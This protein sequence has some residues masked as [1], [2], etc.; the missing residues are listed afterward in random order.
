MQNRL[1]LSG[2]L[3]L[4]CVALSAPS[5]ADEV[6]VLSVPGPGS[7]SFLPAYL[8]KAIGADQAEGLSLKLRYAA[9]G[10]LALRDLNDNNSDF[11]VAGLP[12]IASARADGMPVLAIGQLSQAAIFVLLLR[13]DLKDQIHDISQLKGKRIGT[14]SS[15][16][17]ARSMGAMVAGLILQ[18]AQLKLNDVQ[19]ISTGHSFASAQAALSSG[20]VDAILV[21]EP[22]A[23]ELITRGAAVKLS[24]SSDPANSSDFLGEPVIHAALA[25]RESIY[26]EHPAI[27]KKMQR[28]FARTLAWLAQHTP[29]QVVEQLVEQPGFDASARQATEEL[30]QHN[31]NMFTQ[32]ITWDEQTVANTERFFHRAAEDRKEL[33]LNF[34]EFLRN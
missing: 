31:S 27:V 21:A 34:S 10:P 6:I 33:Q 12:A 19:F 9:G 26:T 20:S 7:L 16:S 25:T 30:L 2:S 5:R 4:L 22:F 32:Q 15:T 24:D 11:A 23:S 17:T 13:A 3:L 8:A 18:H 1:M 28:V 14:P 29:Q